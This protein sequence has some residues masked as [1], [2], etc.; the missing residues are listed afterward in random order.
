MRKTRNRED[1]K[2]EKKKQRDIKKKRENEK[3]RGL[4]E[5]VNVIRK[6]YFSVCLSA[7]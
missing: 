2:R 4:G 6:S 5:M 3:K 1:D 7:R